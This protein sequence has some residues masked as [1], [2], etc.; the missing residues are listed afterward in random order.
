MIYLTGDTH[1]EFRRFQKQ[2]FPEQKEMTKEDFVIILGDFGGVWYR[3]DSKDTRARKTEDHNLDEL[4]ARSFTTL[5]LPGNHENYDR[6]LGEEFPEKSFAGGRVKV[7]R[8]SVYMLMRG[9]MYLLD[10]ARFWAFGGARSH[11]IRDGI[12]K[13]GAPAYKEELKRFRRQ[14]KEFRVEGLSW[15]REELPSEEEM[16]HGRKVL[17]DNG[18]ET[19]FVLTH[20]APSSV[21]KEMGFEDTDRLTDYLEEIHRKLKYKRWFFGHYHDNLQVNEKDIL[22]YEQIIR[23]R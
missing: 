22:L 14:R 9:E 17:Q 5:F 23:V 21:Q 20:C 7:I 4:D 16:A 2:I 19:D 8:P 1:S 18:W 3:S 6:L 12:L 11:D 13:Y 10:G 15:W